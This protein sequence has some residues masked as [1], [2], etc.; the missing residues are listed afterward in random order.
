MLRWIGFLGI[1]FGVVFGLAIAMA[2][3]QSVPPGSYL[4]SCREARD[5]AGWLKATCRD[6]A[7]R[8]VDATMAIAWCPPGNDIVND[9]GRLACGAAGMRN[10]PSPPA[11]PSMSERPPAGSYTATCRDIRMVAGWLKAY[12]QDSRGRWV[13]ATT[14]ASWCTGGRDIANV[15]GRLTCR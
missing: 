15:D 6:R 12:C 5:V 2:N 8:W 11:V 3:A 1:G 14:A 9:N 10:A 13:D 4:D 7:G